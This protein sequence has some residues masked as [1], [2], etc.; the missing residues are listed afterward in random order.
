[1]LSVDKSFL[2]RMRSWLNNVEKSQVYKERPFAFMKSGDQK[3]YAPTTTPPRFHNFL[4]RYFTVI[5]RL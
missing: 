4:E 1:M 3:F 5:Y 2:F